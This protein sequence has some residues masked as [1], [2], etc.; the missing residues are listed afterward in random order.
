MM[1]AFSAASWFPQNSH[2]FLPRLCKAFHNLG[3][4]NYLFA[5]SHEGAQRAAMFYSFFGICKKNNVNPYQWLKKVLEVIPDYP[6]NKIGDLM[7]QN[8]K[9]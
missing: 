3:R 5:G 4:K 9:L 8:L 2:A 7:P 1:A 6:A